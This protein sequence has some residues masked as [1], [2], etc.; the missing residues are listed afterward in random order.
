M[1]VV[2]GMGMGE[3]G[4]SGTA[5]TQIQYDVTAAGDVLRR[6]VPRASVYVLMSGYLSMTTTSPRVTNKAYGSCS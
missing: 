5:R 1:V 6:R 3:G 2:M 4:T